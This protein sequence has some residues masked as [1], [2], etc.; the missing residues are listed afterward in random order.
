MLVDQYPIFRHDPQTG[1]I[2]LSRKQ[3]LTYPDGVSGVYDDQVVKPI[4]HLATKE[5][6]SWK[7]RCMRGSLSR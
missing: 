7:L 5:E 6:P 2:E 1:L 4:F 3:S